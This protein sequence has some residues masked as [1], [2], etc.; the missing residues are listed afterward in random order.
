[1]NYSEYKNELIQAAMEKDPSLKS[2]EEAVMFTSGIKALLAHFK[3]HELYLKGEYLQ[4]A[5][6]SFEAKKETGIEIHP[7]AQ[8]GRRCFIDHGIGVVIGETSIIGDDVMMYHGVTLG[9]L[10]NKKIKRHPTVGN[11]VLIGAGSVILGDIT[12]G[13]NVKIGANA[14]VMKDVPD[15]STAVGVPARIIK[16]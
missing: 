5:E 9:G 14:V 8:I 3:A 4:A 6:I 2:K 11:N 16:H 12:I 15:D 7:G 10:I 1:M 13:N